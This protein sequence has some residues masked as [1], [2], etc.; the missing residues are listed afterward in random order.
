MNFGHVL[1]VAF[2]YLSCVRGDEYSQRTSLC[3]QYDTQRHGGRFFASS[4]DVLS[5]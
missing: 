1:L 2:F 3:S 4:D 5:S